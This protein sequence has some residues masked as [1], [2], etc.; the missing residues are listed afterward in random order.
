MGNLP[1]PPGRPPTVDPKKAMAKAIKA[2]VVVENASQCSF[3]KRPK[4]ICRKSLFHLRSIKEA[5]YMKSNFTINRDSGVAVSEV[6]SVL[7]NKF[8]CC[9][10]PN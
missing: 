8:Q 2:S 4:I 1:L 6:W 3:D 10:L 7:I 9:A 5:L